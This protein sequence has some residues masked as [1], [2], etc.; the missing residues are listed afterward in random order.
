MLYVFSTYFILQLTVWLQA[1][2]SATKHIGSLYNLTIKMMAKKPIRYHHCYILEK[3]NI[4]DKII[5]FFLN[6]FSDLSTFGFL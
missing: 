6:Y 3:Y 1:A 5:I 2:P 4:F